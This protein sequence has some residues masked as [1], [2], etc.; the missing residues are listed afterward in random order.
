[1]VSPLISYPLYHLANTLDKYRFRVFSNHM[2]G[3]MTG[4]ACIT[5]EAYFVHAPSFVAFGAHTIL[6]IIDTMVCVFVKDLW[7]L[8]IGKLL[9]FKIFNRIY[10][11]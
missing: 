6:S 3:R 8:N 5:G 4:D 2:Y 10:D 9:L 11:L 1:M 7:E